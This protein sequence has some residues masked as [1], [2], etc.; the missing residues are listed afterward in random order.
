MKRK[1]FTYGLTTLFAIGFAGFA[2]GFSVPSLHKAGSM[3]TPVLLDGLFGG[4][5]EQK[6]EVPLYPIHD[7]EAF[8][9]DELM[10]TYEI[11]P[12][13]TVE[14]GF[15][16]RL[17]KDWAYTENYEA[18][19]ET[20]LNQKLLGNIARF[21]S[22]RISTYQ[23]RVIVQAL[24]MPHQISAKH[25]L[26]HHIL[27]SGFTPDSE[28]IS[29][30]PREASGYYIYLEDGNSM[31]TYIRALINKDTMLVAKF[32]IPT[33]MKTYM[34]YIQKKTLESFSLTYPEEGPI[35]DMKSFTLVDSIKLSFP[36]SWL[37]SDPDFRDMNRLLVSLKNKSESGSLQGFVH[38]M[39]IR[40]NR[41]TS[42]RSELEN[43]K[44]YFEDTM[45]LQFDRL[46]SSSKS[47]AYDRFMF[48][49]YEIYEVKNKQRGEVPQMLHLAV[50]GDKEWYVI[51]FLL[52]PREDDNLYNWARNVASFEAILQS[53]K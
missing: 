11:V 39:A 21:D 6:K 35:E 37:V 48:N 25:W 52:S 20:E 40:R 51:L 36:G 32:E 31:R 42:L 13:Q 41:N 26:R 46:E 18:K 19:T 22:P 8:N 27:I 44:T 7:D 23:P 24:K 5:E 10:K 49:R 43:L 12:Y 45:K 3:A 28:I 50:L 9:N 16:I 47:P 29:K 53:I 38:V 33:Q 1:I 34:E 2:Y 17:P 4:K 15:S 14:L 30:N